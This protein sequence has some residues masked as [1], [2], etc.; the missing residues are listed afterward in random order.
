ME[1]IHYLVFAES[2]DTHELGK[3]RLEVENGCETNSYGN[4]N[5]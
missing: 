1:V 2:T 5:P 4:E 3:V